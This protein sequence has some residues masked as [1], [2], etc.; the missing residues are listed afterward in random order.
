VPPVPLPPDVD[1]FLRRPNPAVIATLRPDGA[2]HTAATWY[3]WDGEAIFLNMDGSRARLPWMR[4][5]GRVAL[6]VLDAES[7]YVHA[8]L[9][10]R[11]TR[12]EDDPD[13]SGI[14]RLSLRYRGQPYRNRTS[15]R[16]SA[17]MTVERWHGWTAAGL[18]PAA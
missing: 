6:T 4:R 11:V 14:D 3:D 12:I 15:P 10:G 8:S 18:W 13:L 7:W 2:P 9:L 1:A 16:V 5:D 17:W